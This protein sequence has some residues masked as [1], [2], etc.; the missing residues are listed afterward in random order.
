M[1]HEKRGSTR[2]LALF[3][4][5]VDMWDASKADLVSLKSDPKATRERSPVVSV[6]WSVDGA[7]VLAL[8]DGTIQIMDAWLSTVCSPIM[9]YKFARPLQLLAAS[10]RATVEYNKTVLQLKGASCFDHAGEEIA[11]MGPDAQMLVGSMPPFAAAHYRQAKSIMERCLLTAILFGDQYEIKFWTLLKHYSAVHRDSADGI[12]RDSD[13][14]D[15]D[16]ARDLRSAGSAA[17]D[18]KVRACPA[19]PHTLSPSCRRNCTH[20]ELTRRERECIWYI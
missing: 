15:L 9:Q 2:F 4:D 18:L 8:A 3:D 5:G 12:P 7:P 13:T 19:C 6:G 17:E 1:F 10:D 11:A 14:V 16:R 20:L